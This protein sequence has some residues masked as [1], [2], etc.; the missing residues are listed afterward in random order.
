V[1]WFLVYDRYYTL[2]YISMKDNQKTIDALNDLIKINNDRIEG[3][4]KAIKESAPDANNDSLF[5]RMIEQSTTIRGELMD[6]VRRI[7]GNSTKSDT[8]NS[9][10]LYRMWMD[11]KSTFAWNSKTSV[12]ELCEFGED[13]AQ[14]SYKESLASA[15][16]MADGT[17]ELIMAQKNRLKES[18]D[19]IKTKRDMQR[20]MDK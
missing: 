16:E 20:V 6:E 3:Y 1:A 11:V 17:R 10:K 13:A 15:D 4:E 8:T 12:L 18:H 19:L 14:K 2:N 7:G 9:G 5:D